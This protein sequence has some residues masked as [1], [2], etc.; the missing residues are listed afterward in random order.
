MP[1]GNPPEAILAPRENLIA[2]VAES[3]L[4]TASVVWWSSLLWSKWHVR[5]GVPEAT[6]VILVVAVSL[7]LTWA[8]W[9][10][11]RRLQPLNLTLVTARG[12][13]ALTLSLWLLSGG[14]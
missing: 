6:A 5:Y 11:G 10:R 3:L 13:G 14:S 7:L 12:I 1:H 4:S 9:L 8:L 2:L